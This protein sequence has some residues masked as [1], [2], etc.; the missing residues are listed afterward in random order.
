SM[1]GYGAVKLGLKHPGMFASVNAHSGALAAQRD[2]AWLKELQPEFDRIFGKTPKGGHEDPFAV[3]E[4]ID[5]GR[6]PALLIDCGT[7]D[8]L[9]DQNRAF[10]PHLESLHIPHEYQ[11]FLGDHDWAYWDK[12]V[13][14]AVAFHARNLR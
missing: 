5:H 4:Q 8:H 12:H 6:I 3:A 2:S 13:Q 7:E 10:H 9:L 1:G 11:E 14:E